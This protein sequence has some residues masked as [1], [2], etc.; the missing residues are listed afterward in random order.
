MDIFKNAKSVGKSS[1]KAKDNQRPRDHVDGLEDYGNLVAMGKTLKTMIETQASICNAQAAEHFVNEALLYGKV[2]KSYRGTDGDVTASMEL[3]KRSSASGLNEEEIA[4]CEKYKVKLEVVEDRPETYIFNPVY[5]NDEKLL[6]RI[7]KAL[8]KVPGMPA[9]LIQKQESTKK[10]IITE[11]A[12]DA[13]FA[14]KDEDTIRAMMP[15]VATQAIKPTVPNFDP[16][17]AMKMIADL[18]DPSKIFNWT[19]KE[20]EVVSSHGTKKKIEA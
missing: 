1:T 18:L 3:R 5:V 19:K 12:M 11:E 13:V 6:Q 14:T 9:D 20:R 7:A 2:G 17:S 10:T 16:L 15:I 8:E 4:V